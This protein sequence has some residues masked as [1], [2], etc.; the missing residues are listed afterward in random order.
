MAEN[1]HK[2][3]VLEEKAWVLKNSHIYLGVKAPIK[4]EFYFP[5]LQDYKVASF[6]PALQKLFDEV[7][8]NCTDE[9]IRTKFEFATKISVDFND[10][11][12]IT[13]KDTGRGL[14]IEKHD[15]F[16]ELWTPEV[17]FTK[18][19]SGSN[20]EGDREGSGAHGLGISL[21]SL[22]SDLFTVKTYQNKKVYTQTF[23]NMLDEEGTPKVTSTTSDKHGTEITFIPNFDY[24]GEKTWNY[25]MLTKKV[26]DMAFLFPQIKF[27]LNGEN[28]KLK[29]LKDY[30]VDHT[31][32][33][34]LIEGKQA[35]IMVT[36]DLSGT[37]R[38][39]AILNGANTFE[40]GSHVDYPLN[41]IIRYLRPKLE[42]KHKIELRPKDIRDHIGFFVWLQ[43]K[44]PQYTS[45]TKEKITNPENEIKDY[46]DDI[47]KKAF[48]DKILKNKPII[49]KIIEE[50]I[51]KRDIKNQVDL[52]RKQKAKKKAKSAKL[53]EANSKERSE[54]TLFITEG[55][56]AKENAAPVRNTDYHAFMPL[57]GKILNVFNM[58]GVEAYK[59][60][61]IQDIMN[62]IGLEFGTKAIK[63][64]LRYGK[65]CILTDADTDGGHISSL[66]VN[67]FFRYWPELFDQ[68]I[69]CMMKAP[70]YIAKKG[71]KK[72]YIYDERE[73]REKESSIKGYDVSYFKG[74]AGLEIEDWDYFLNKNPLYQTI[75]YGE[76]PELI[77][78]IAFGPDSSK[79]KVW[80]GE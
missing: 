19:R 27:K 16:P 22:F 23:K 39:T 33:Y 73:Y 34:E 70:L 62:T 60:N 43:M 32:D 4:K 46:F 8:E 50:A 74:L 77:I 37:G 26:H 7:I 45:Q 15:Q 6:V 10:D 61:E 66:L 76:S 3:K 21:V 18:L 29:K 47:M 40:G 44:N 64:E 41:E 36:S 5:Q 42:K 28:I 68:G 20:F 75:E 65:I 30:I 59:S 12:S 11:G 71:K 72:I 63:S 35:K 24:F 1:E 79:R 25:D 17:I 2:I 31:E 9:A 49:E 58:P 13:I 54:C 52:K 48:F 55:D 80:L 67:F 78:D 56:S 38:F 14:P 51:A 57:R 53:V 69:V